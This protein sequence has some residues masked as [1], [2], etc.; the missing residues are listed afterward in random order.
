MRL[1]WAVLC[2]HAIVEQETN[3]LS[4]IDVIEQINIEFNDNVVPPATAPAALPIPLEL[5]SLWQRGP[6][7]SGGTFK[8]TLRTPQGAES[9]GHAIGTIE[10]GLAPRSRITTRVP[11]LPWRGEGEYAFVVQLS[12]KSAWRTIADVPFWIK[13]KAPQAPLRQQQTPPDAPEKTARRRPTAK[14]QARKQRR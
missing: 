11:N 8:I 14:R 10:Q 5:I 6:D 7:G 2:R 12:T 13:L 4:L 9:Q 1:I 3:T